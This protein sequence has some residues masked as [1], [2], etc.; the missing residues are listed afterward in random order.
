M[1]RTISLAF[2]FVCMT[3]LP[4]SA[5]QPTYHGTF[6][7]VLTGSTG[8]SLSGTT[9]NSGTLSGGTLSS[10]TLS[11]PTLSGTMNGSG[12][13]STTGNIGTNAVFQIFTT[14]GC[15]TATTL[16]STAS[17]IA[18][19]GGQALSVQ[20]NGQPYLNVDNSGNVASNGA[21]ASS[22]QYTLSNTTGCGSLG[23]AMFYTAAQ[24]RGIGG[25]TVAF[26][27]IGNNPFL[28]VDN[29]GNVAAAGGMVAGSFTNSSSPLLKRDI[30]PFTFDA[31]A[32]LKRM[33]RLDDFAQFRLNTD[34]A[35]HWLRTGPLADNRCAIEICPPPVS[36]KAI[37]RGVDLEALAAVDGKAIVQLEKRVAA[38]QRDLAALR[39]EVGLR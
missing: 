29:T 21:F 1:L 25:Q 7:G 11:N 6:V 13:I 23:T 34:P 12:V 32:A 17:Q 20:C 22:V 24:I 5:A 28:N 37:D 26:G 30:Q 38:L 14:V 9:T 39:R 18:G 8:S 31:L 19:V 4:L 36:G 35:D 10:N 3:L 33:D 27:C 2:M 16:T 15:S